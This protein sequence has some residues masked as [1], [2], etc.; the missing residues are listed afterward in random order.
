MLAKLALTSFLAVASLAV[1]A[2]PAGAQGH[3]PCA[4]YNNCINACPFVDGDLDPTCV[5]NC[6]PLQPLGIICRKPG[7]PAK[8]RAAFVR[9]R[10]PMTPIPA[11][12]LK[13]KTAAVHPIVAPGA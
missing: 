9:T 7:T 13:A 5:A 10:K 12:A 11:G 8:H 3:D 4:A 2:S 1:V 6:A